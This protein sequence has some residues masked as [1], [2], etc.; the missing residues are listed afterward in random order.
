MV[1]AAIAGT[2]RWC[3]VTY[4]I[5]DEALGLLRE[6]LV[7]RLAGDRW[8][9]VDQ[10]VRSLAAALAAG[11][12]DAFREVLYDLELAGPIRVVRIE[13]AEILPPP[14]PVRERINQLVHTLEGA[15]GSGEDDGSAD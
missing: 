6:V 4:D 10:A 12:P 8:H 11:E 1:R 3:A 13:D 7:W 5:H 9:I 14:P 2:I 15:G